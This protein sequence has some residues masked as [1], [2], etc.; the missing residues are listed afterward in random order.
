M[1][2]CLEANIAIICACLP[3]FR[4]PLARAFPRFFTSMSNSR[5]GMSNYPGSFSKAGIGKNDW[6]PSQ[7]GVGSKDVHLTSVIGGRETGSEEYILQDRDDQ[8]V[9]SANRG[10][11]TKTTHFSVKYDDEASV[12][13]A[14]RS[15]VQKVESG[16]VQ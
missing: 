6:T 3:M 16:M 5:T 2:T 15:P 13:S 12:V 8:F 14:E 4:M 10:Q 11:I 9:G 7:S 1:W